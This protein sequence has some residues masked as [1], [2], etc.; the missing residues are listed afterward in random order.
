LAHDP[1]P[2]YSAGGWRERD[3]G[4]TLMRRR[5]FGGR[6]R[7]I[8]WAP[9]MAMLVSSFALADSPSSTARLELDNQNTVEQGAS[10]SPAVVKDFPETLWEAVEVLEECHIK[11]VRRQQLI[12]WAIRGLYLRLDEKL[13][14]TVTSRLERINRL[15]KKELKRLLADA[16]AHLG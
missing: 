5:L 15:N 4:R 12:E 7:Q 6:S 14:A 16:R 13:P 8:M 9:V 2:G 1:Q 10:L 3:D 11:K